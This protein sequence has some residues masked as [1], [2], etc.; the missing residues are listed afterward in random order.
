MI[1]GQISNYSCTTNSIDVK[2]TYSYAYHSAWNPTLTCAL[3]QCIV[4]RTTNGS[5]RSNSTLC[6]SYRL[7]NNQSIC[8]PPIDCSILEPCDNLTHQCQS[9]SSVCVINSCCST[10]AVCVP[11][12]A[13]SFCESSRDYILWTMDNTLNDL[14]QKYVG[15][16]LNSTSY[17]SGINGYG[18]ALA[19]NGIYNQCAV[20]SPYLNMSYQSFTWEFWMYV[21]GNAPEVT[22]IGQ[23]SNSSILDEC[24]QLNIFNNTLWFTFGNDDIISNTALFLNTWYHIGFVY[25]TSTNRKSLYLNGFL[26]QT[27]NSSGLLRVTPINMTFGCLTT[28]NGNNY[29]NYFTGYLDQISFTYRAKTANEILDDAT[30]VLYYR[31]RSNELLLDSGPNKINGTFGNTVSLPSGVVD[32]AIDLSVNA[33]YFLAT[34]LVL[35]GTSSW[36]FSL[37]FWYKRHLSTSDSMIVR[38]STTLTGDGGWC[39][40]YFVINTYGV[41]WIGFRVRVSSLFMINGP[42]IVVAETG[43]VR[44][45]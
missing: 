24:L 2:F 7:I 43:R 42:I 11:S 15:N 37:T 9:T 19:L 34:N 41:L 26:D 14:E 36:P 16:N 4:N 17:V 44:V 35:F 3:S 1:L 31:F 8:A 20:I 23:C 22:L 28:D 39:P 6:F 33:S 12:I 32:Q 18:S 30:L 5:C 25:D 21:T 10:N 27:Q 38:L 13:T 40:L 45:H 29:R